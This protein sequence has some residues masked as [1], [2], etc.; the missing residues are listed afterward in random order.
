M[1]RGDTPIDFSV[2]IDI[3]G[4]MQA[5]MGTDGDRLNHAKRAVEILLKQTLRPNDSV[6]VSTFNTQG[7]VVQPLQ[8]VGAIDQ[9]SFLQSVQDLRTS[10]ATTLSA[11][12]Y[13]RIALVT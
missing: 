11:G 10:G 2:V 12:N 7:V 8:Q 4:S 9:S 6:G 13:T 5:R 1:P 3:S